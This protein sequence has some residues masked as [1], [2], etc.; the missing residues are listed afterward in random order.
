MFL[1]PCVNNSNYKSMRMTDQSYQGFDGEAVASTPAL[2]KPESEKKKAEPRVR[3]FDFTDYREFLKASYEQKKANNPSFSESAF[4]RRAGLSRNSRGYF[5]MIV[6]GKRNLTPATIRAFSDALA[7]DSKES[8]YFEN[9]V[10]FNQAT[11]AKD[12]DYYFQ[13]LM[14]ASEGNRTKPIHFLESQYSFYSRWY[15]VAVRELVG[16]S[17]FD[18]N[19]AWIAA[20]L[21]NKITKAEAAEALVHLERLELIK[22]NAEGRLVQS[23]PLMKFPGNKLNLTIQKFHSEML[24]RAKEALAEDDYEERRASCLTLSCGRDKLPELI[25]MVDQFRHEMNLRF[26]ADAAPADTVFQVGFQIFQLTPPKN[27]EIRHE[28]SRTKT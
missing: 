15:I 13:R 4:V 18:E 23:E 7:L 5:K 19:P 16:L 9:L 11:K 26:G 3:A 12:R 14:A 20:M 6:Q 8:I 22:R 2:N 1:L 21:R 27:K 25:K 10:L 28:Q 24:D 17:A